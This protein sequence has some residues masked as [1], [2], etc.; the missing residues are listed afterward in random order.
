MISNLSEQLVV[1]KRTLGSCALLSCL[2]YSGEGL[3]VLFCFFLN[4]DRKCV[5]V[6]LKI[7]EEEMAM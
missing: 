3:S 5:C 1:E 2:D 4:A 6:Y 7:E